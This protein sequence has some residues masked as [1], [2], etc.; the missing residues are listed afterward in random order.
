MSDFYR[1]RRTTIKDTTALLAFFVGFAWSG[2]LAWPFLTSQVDRGEM[3]RGLAYFLAVVLATAIIAGWLGLEAGSALGGMWE[4][5]HR[6][7]RAARP[8]LEAPQPPTRPT[9]AATPGRA[10]SSHDISAISYDDRQIDPQSFVYLAQR[11]AGTSYESQRVGE[12]LGKTI[13][14]GAWDGSR[15]VGT[16]RVLSDGYL[17]S[18][19]TEIMV[20]PEYQ[21]IG[22][23]SALMRRALDAA[24][25]ERLLIS[26]P[27]ATARF[28][29]H[30]GCEQEPAGF[31][32]KKARARVTPRG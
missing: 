19:V 7:R 3:I 27:R 2:A 18:T 13:N 6:R 12:A 8:P 31:V 23:G 25:R 9:T 17:F 20:D 22:I 26:P 29:E 1:V 28:F 21:G 11:V 5:Y 15:L 32:L 10:A 16:V 14:I 30:I 4:K 24:P